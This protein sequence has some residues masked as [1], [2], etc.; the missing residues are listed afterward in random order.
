MADASAPGTPIDQVN[1]TAEPSKSSSGCS[2]IPSPRAAGLWIVLGLALVG[3]LR[4]GV[5]RRRSRD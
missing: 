4:R 1:P 2:F 3:R 5:N